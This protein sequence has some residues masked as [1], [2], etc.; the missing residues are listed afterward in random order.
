MRICLKSEKN[1]SNEKTYV[2]L[3]YSELGYGNVRF[4][5]TLLFSV[6]DQFSTQPNPVL[7]NPG[8]KARPVRYNRV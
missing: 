8:Y 1:I 2:K 7:T 6:I 4:Y 3:D 5:W